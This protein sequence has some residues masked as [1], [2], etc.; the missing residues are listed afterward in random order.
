[1][2]VQ[3]TSKAVFLNIMLNKLQMEW[4][5][6]LAV[7]S[8]EA[9]AHISHFNITFGESYFRINDNRQIQDVYIKCF[10]LVL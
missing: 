10:Y 1:M 7:P 5:D 3:A 9:C 6:L 8:G 2:F 4:M